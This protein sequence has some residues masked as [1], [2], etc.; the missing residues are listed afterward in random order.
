MAK[1]EKKKK[2]TNVLTS[3][4]SI[5]IQKSPER[6]NP[7]SAGGFNDRKVTWFNTLDDDVL[8]IWPHDDAFGSGSKGFVLPITGGE[9][10]TKKLNGKPKGTHLQYLVWNIAKKRFIPGNSHPEIII[11]G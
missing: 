5:V 7:G 2:K 3:D 1:R 10:S 6:V 8:L 11:D 4:T 9:S